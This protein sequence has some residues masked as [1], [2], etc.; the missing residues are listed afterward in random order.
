MIVCI[1]AS[2]LPVASAGSANDDTADD[3]WRVVATKSIENCFGDRPVACEFQVTGPAK[4]PVR[5]QWQVLIERRVWQRGVVRATTAA[6]DKPTI[7]AFEFRTPFVK[8]GVIAGGR[9][10]IQLSDD[11]NDDLLTKEFPLW[12]YHE[13]PFDTEFAWLK[14]LSIELVDPSHQL[15]NY[16]KPFSFPGKVETVQAKDERVLIVAQMAAWDASVTQQIEQRLRD[17]GQVLCLATSR[18]Q[19]RLNSLAP[20]GLEM[21]GFPE[22]HVANFE[23]MRQLDPRLGNHDL[24]VTGRGRIDY[25]A[26]ERVSWSI[27]S[28]RAG[29]AFL[30][31]GAETSPEWIPDHKTTFTSPQQVSRPRLVYCG[32][33]LMSRWQ[34]SPTPRYLLANILQRMCF[35]P[36]LN[37]PSKELP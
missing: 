31:A 17:G 4:Q 37:L 29:W 20:G 36:E 28:S 27:T 33:D 8:A 5:V 19:L 7:V 15:T 14:Q 16:L 1:G 9:L 25:G 34:E 24:V 6:D 3:A 10:K 23:F 13:N 35:E 32:L 26:D 21:P 2:Q 22:I 30:E 18:G 12:I 11:Q